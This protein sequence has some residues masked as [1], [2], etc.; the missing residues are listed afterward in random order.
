MSLAFD[1]SF[2]H[3]GLD[4]S[5]ANGDVI[6]SGFVL[7]VNQNMNARQQQK[8]RS[9]SM[10]G[11]FYQLAFPASD[12]ED[13]SKAD[14]D[15]SSLHNG[16]GAYL[17]NLAAENL[18]LQ[19]KLNRQTDELK[20][21]RAQLRGYDY[22]HDASSD[23][24]AIDSLRL[25]S[26]SK[27]NV[28]HSALLEVFNVPEFSRILIC[29]LKPRVA[30][31]LTPCLPAYLMLAGFRYQDHAKDEEGLTGLFSTLHGQ[32]KETVNR[33]NDLDVLILW[34]VNSWSLFNL[35]RQYSGEKNKEWATGNTEKQNGH[36]M[37]NFSVE[38]I[39]NQLKMRIDNCYQKLMKSAIEP[40]LIPKIVPG[41][42]HHDSAGAVMNP[43]N[44]KLTRQHSKDTVQLQALDDLIEFLNMIYTKLKFF[45]ADP[46]LIGQIFSQIS[47]W[48]CALALN[49]L[50]F[51]K[52]LCSFEKAIQIKHNTNEVCNWLNGKGLKAYADHLEPLIQASHLLM[53]QKHE[54]NLDV[55]CGEMTSRL[56]KKQILA[57]L[58]HYSPSDGFEEDAIDF[59]FLRKV[60]DKLAER[61]APDGSV[62]GGDQLIVPGT[63]LTP[64]DAQPFVHSDFPLET[65]SLPACIR[66]NSVSRLL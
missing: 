13:Y 55:L 42:L 50:M 19:D 11:D 34:M 29:D 5:A 3:I 8:K 26:L 40:V 43:V 37:Q 16:N 66:L 61:P 53:S 45:G 48:I 25:D 56:G 24:G 60:G 12:D 20:E 2:S 10:T 7:D 57:I 33:S 54:A 18:S 41:I 52:D 23:S 65:L 1:E 58:Q 6:P 27:E 17:V 30:K 64:F 22:G 39:R 44:T 59:N 21:T 36:K 49:H 63:Y 4:G 35:L 32:I 47:H 38:P 31:Q 51:R 28:E 9:S 46:V 14:S 62:G 15:Q